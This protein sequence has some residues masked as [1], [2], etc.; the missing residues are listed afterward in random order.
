M[1]ATPVRPVEPLLPFDVGES[2]LE[3]PA[4]VVVRRNAVLPAFI[5]I[6]ASAIATAYLYRAVE[7]SAVT[8]W[9]LC[10][11][12]ALV[13]VTYLVALLD[14]RTPLLVADDLGVRIRLGSQWR[15]VPWEAVDRVVVEPRPG[16]LRDGRMRVLLHHVARA[17]EG[18]D[19]RG[20]RAARRNQRRYGA[21]LAVPL[22]LTTRTGGPQATLAERVDQLAQGRADVVALSEPQR[23]ETSADAPPEPVEPVERVEPAVEEPGEPA[24]DALVPDLD[25]PAGEAGLEPE[26][27]ARRRPR[28]RGRLGTAVSRAGAGRSRDVD[29]S[30]AAAA[31]PD[32]E[33]PASPAQPRP[34]RPGPVPLAPAARALPLPGAGTPTVHQRLAGADPAAAA[35]AA[36][37]TAAELPESRAELPESVVLRRPDADPF[38]FG[39]EGL[40]GRSDPL[41]RE[42]ADHPGVRRIATLR[43]P[44]EPPVVDDFATEPAY[45]PVIGPQ[46][47]AARTR[48]GL[49]VD[50]LAD[51]TRIRPHVIES[52]EVDDFAPCGG[53]FYARGHIR[54]LARVLGQDVDPMLRHFEDRYA[55]AP[56]NPR[57]VFEAELATGLSGSARRRSGGPSWSLLVG[58]VLVLVLVW[59]AVRLFAGEGEPM[60]SNPPPALNGSAGLG[61]YD[62]PAPQAVPAEARLTAEGG[63]T[64]VRVTDAGDVVVFEGDLAD[65]EQVTV[66][67]DAPLSVAAD[68]GGALR[69]SVDGEDRGLLGEPG[70]PAEQTF[71]RSAG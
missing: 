14:S 23:D 7:T 54:T 52:I 56:V 40:P 25:D 13:A 28:L 16:P 60:L 57:R 45:D 41:S 33:R 9:A 15:A 8:D 61:G 32:P 63:E 43:E 4:E 53:D 26:P 70:Q 37:V 38:G 65:G 35:A 44:V 27:S 22:G 29:R 6:A 2:S 58:L 20:R 47:A 21:A 31:G 68:Q 64:H 12:M 17:V 18:L 5:G 30:G 59:S 19:G 49:S 66:H 55:T 67:G 50:E 42:L 1:S 34:A 51:R 24:A 48:V 10:G 39:D 46:L 71:Q 62:A 36:A 11:L 3:P 69:V